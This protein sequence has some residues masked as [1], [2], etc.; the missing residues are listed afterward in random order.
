MANPG[1]AQAGEVFIGGALSLTGIQAPLDEPTLRGAKVAVKALNDA[2][3]I[4]GNKVKFVNLDG[5]SD[6]VTVGNV[7]VQLIS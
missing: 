6:P 2:G 7:A 3:G 4:L 5:K 1:G